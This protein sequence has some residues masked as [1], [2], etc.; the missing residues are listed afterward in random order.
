MRATIVHAGV[1]VASGACTTS[2][3]IITND[4]A[5]APISS[6]TQ[7]N[8]KFNVY[9]YCRLIDEDHGSVRS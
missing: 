8:G 2:T 6:S 9:Y 1:C 4:A 5:N 7:L 3:Q